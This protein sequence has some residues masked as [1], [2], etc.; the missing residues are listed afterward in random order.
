MRRLAASRCRCK[1]TIN[2]AA[3]NNVNGLSVDATTGRAR[4]GDDKGEAF[5]GK[6]FDK[7][8]DWNASEEG[9]DAPLLKPRE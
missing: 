2:A 6:V 4:R 8:K 3:T 1:H 9:L 7:H 5:G